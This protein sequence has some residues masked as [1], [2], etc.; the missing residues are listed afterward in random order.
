VDSAKKLLP[1]YTVL[2]WLG[3]V[4]AVDKVNWKLLQDRSVVIWPDNDDA[5]KKADKILQPH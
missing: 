2:S 3:G 5:G 4:S 1:E